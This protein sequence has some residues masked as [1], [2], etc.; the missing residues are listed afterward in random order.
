M[1]ERFLE[2]ETLGPLI[3]VAPLASVE[4]TESW[5]LSRAAVNDSDESIDENLMPIVSSFLTLNH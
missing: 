1:N 2:V 3:K 5:L 4:H